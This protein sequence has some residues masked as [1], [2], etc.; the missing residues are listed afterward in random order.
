VKLWLIVKETNVNLLS[1]FA[2]NA[3]MNIDQLKILEN[4]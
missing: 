3:M 2:K 1:G 4:V